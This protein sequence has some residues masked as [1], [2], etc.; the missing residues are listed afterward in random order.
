MKFSIA[1][2]VAISALFSQA[3]AAKVIH[4]GGPHDLKCPDGLACCGPVVDGVGG[5]CVPGTADVC[6]I[7]Y[8][9]QPAKQNSG[10]YN[11]PRRGGQNEKC[12]TDATQKE[13]TP[14]AADAK[15]Q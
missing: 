5:T 11:P 1:S 2:I 6:K 13:A 10:S 3:L 9:V 4:C 12:T 14:K 7:P 8:K 15:N